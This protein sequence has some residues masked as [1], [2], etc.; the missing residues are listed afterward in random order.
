M[1]RNVCGVL[2]KSNSSYVFPGEDDIENVDDVPPWGY[3]R[4]NDLG[5][6]LFRTMYGTCLRSINLLFCRKLYY[7]SLHYIRILQLELSTKFIRN[8]LVASLSANFN[9]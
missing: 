9:K 6:F 3:G 5:M 7:K 4:T 2:L 1:R 8:F